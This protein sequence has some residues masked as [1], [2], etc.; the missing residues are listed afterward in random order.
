MYR[1]IDSLAGAE[2]ASKMNG[3]ED[4]LEGVNNAE[5]RSS[6]GGYIRLTHAR[7]RRSAETSVGLGSGGAHHFEILWRD[8]GWT[9]FGSRER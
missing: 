1:S 6:Y 3:E 4:W 9:N 7:G 8:D 2:L 5:A